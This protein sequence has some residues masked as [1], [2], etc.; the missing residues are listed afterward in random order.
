MIAQVQEFD[1]TCGCPDQI[2]EKVPKYLFPG[3]RERNGSVLSFR[4]SLFLYNGHAI[5]SPTRDL[6]VVEGFPSVWWLHQCGFPDTVALMGNYCS[7]AQA[8]LIR[9]LTR[10]SSRI[11]LMPD[12][13]Q[14]GELCADSL[15][16]H[17]A[18]HRFCHWVKLDEGQ[19]TNLSPE[20]LM[21][22]LQ[23]KAEL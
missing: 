9:S 10:S 5:H 11:W 2:G 1:G 20:D 17:I 13:G 3:E 19:P 12:S 14:G 16:R 18:P 6:Y 22:L 21:Q 15:L 8:D 23:W 7:E 4:K